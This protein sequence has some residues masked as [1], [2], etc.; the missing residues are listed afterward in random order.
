M[1]DERARPNICQWFAALEARST[2]MGTQSDMHTHCHD[3]PPQ[4]GG[5]FANG[6]QQQRVAATKVDQGPWRDLPDTCVSE[7]ETAAVSAA[8]PCFH[9]RTRRTRYASSVTHT[10]QLE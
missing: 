5:C 9:T 7:P 2:Y 6:E 10:R 1:R 4:M 8:P 3:L